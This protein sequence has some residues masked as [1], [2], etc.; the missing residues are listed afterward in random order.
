VTLVRQVADLVVIGLNFRPPDS[1]NLWVTP[2]REPTV[3]L[4]LL[5]VV[6]HGLP[7][8]LPVLNMSQRTVYAELSNYFN[9]QAN[10]RKRTSEWRPFLCLHLFLI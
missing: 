5:F 4:R 10:E 8:G 7:H 3:A 2:L 1:L 6:D 9:E